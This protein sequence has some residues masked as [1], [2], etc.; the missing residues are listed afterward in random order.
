MHIEKIILKL[1]SGTPPL[2]RF[3]GLRKTALKEL[4]LIGPR[5]VL[6]QDY[7][8]FRFQSLLFEQ[9]EKSQKNTSID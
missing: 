5:L 3:L 1:I 8:T 6:M 2:T 7:G 4:S 9:S